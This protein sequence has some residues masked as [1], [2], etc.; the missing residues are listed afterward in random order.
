MKKLHLVLMLALCASPL[1]AQQ[2]GRTIPDAYDPF[3]KNLF[4][5][6]LVM[7]H[8][9]DIGL[10][11]AQRDLI[12]TEIQ[13]AQSSFTDFQ[14]KLAEESGKLQ[15]LAPFKVARVLTQI[16]S[17]LAVEREMKRTQIALLI[18]IRN[19]LTPEQR[20]RLAQAR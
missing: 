2:K 15:K 6:E 11:D 5:P 1:A 17:I 20:A 10:R 3:A 7:Q 13:K 14:F 19:A 9:G 16:D 18:R 4:P 12:R 8:Q